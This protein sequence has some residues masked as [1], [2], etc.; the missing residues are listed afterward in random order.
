[1]RSNAALGHLGLMLGI[2][3]LLIMMDRLIYAS[4]YS[5]Y[6]GAW[7]GLAFI[8][9]IVGVAL[10]VAEDFRGGRPA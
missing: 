2:L 9:W 8:L 3:G 6:N 5:S 10:V 1:M 4:S 7:F